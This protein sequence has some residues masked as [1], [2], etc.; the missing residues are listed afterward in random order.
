MTRRMAAIA[1]RAKIIDKLLAKGQ[2]SPAQARAILDLGDAVQL[3]KEIEEL[4]AQIAELQRGEQPAAKRDD[5]P[6]KPSVK[7]IADNS[8]LL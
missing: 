3:Q 4:K 7:R 6:R 8:D 2:I 5:K 1:E